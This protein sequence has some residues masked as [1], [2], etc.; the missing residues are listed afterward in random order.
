ME[1]S[2]RSLKNLVGVHPDL[3]AVVKLA[4]E[5]AQLE[6]IVTEGVRTQA[7][8]Q[9]LYDAGASKTLNSRHIPGADKFGK[10]VDLA[11]VVD[12]EVRWDWPLYAKL[13]EQ[14]RDAALDARVSITWGGE[15]KSFPDGPHFELSR[16]EYP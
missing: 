9:S 8:Q 3:V 4:A 10:A 2:A 11:A 6:F 15:W 14:M 5:R 13:A 16:R 7:R 1:L 12:G